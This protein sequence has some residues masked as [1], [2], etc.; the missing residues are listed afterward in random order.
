MIALVDDT[1][2]AT[3]ERLIVDADLVSVRP[4]L[5]AGM[6]P[7]FTGLLP[8]FPAAA[9]QARSDLT[10]LNS[11]A[12][13]ALRAD[14][15]TRAP[16]CRFLTNLAQQLHP[17]AEEQDVLD[18]LAVASS[19]SNVAHG[20]VGRLLQALAAAHPE[21]D[22]IEA[23]AA[24]AA[25]PV[26]HHPAGLDAWRVW[27]IA[28]HHAAGAHDDSLVQLLVAARDAAP[29]G[30]DR[31]TIADLIVHNDWFG[32]MGDAADIH[33]RIQGAD[34]SFA[35]NW[36]EVVAHSTRVTS[37]TLTDL[38]AVGGA[39]PI[40]HDMLRVERSGLAEVLTRFERDASRP[41]MV[42]V[43]DA[44]TGKSSLV[45][46]WAAKLAAGGDAVVLT[47][48]ARL[49][50]RDVWEQLRIDLHLPAEGDWLAA[51]GRAATDAGA[52]VTIIVDDGDEYLDGGVTPASLFASI[53]RRL[54]E[55][56]DGIRV[57]VV[58]GQ[59]T[60]RRI[61][62]REAGAL[63]RHRYFGDGIEPTVVVPEYTDDEFASAWARCQQVFEVSTG[64]DQLPVLLRAQMHNPALAVLVASTFKGKSVPAHEVVAAVD[65]FRRY[66]ELQTRAAPDFPDR[67]FLSEL[68]LSMYQQHSSPI[69]ILLL[70]RL[71][72][73][74]R[75]LTDQPDSV[76]NRLLD[77]GVL[78]RV[79]TQQVPPD[80]IEFTMSQFGAWVLA[81]ALRIEQHDALE[82]I[83]A[84][85]EHVDEYPPIVETIRILASAV[86][87]PHRLIPFADDARPAVRDVLVQALRD[88]SYTKP[89]VAAEIVRELVF[90]QGADQARTIERRRTGMMAAFE[91]SVA[92]SADDLTSVFVE[93][94]KGKDANLRADALDVL[95]MIWRTHPGFTNGVLSAMADDVAALKP[96][97][98]RRLVLFMGDL[99]I[100]LYT[101][102]PGWDVGEPTSELWH[103]VAVDRLHADRFDIPG[104]RELILWLADRVFSGKIFDGFLLDDPDAVR[105]VL[106][107]DAEA[108]QPLRAG[109][110][111]L[112]PATDIASPAPLTLL[113]TLFRSPHQVFRL[114]A[115]QATAVHAANDFGSAEPVVRELFG[116]LD[117]DGRMWL[118]MS[119]GVLIDRTPPEWAPV[120]DELAAA[121]LAA[122]PEL[123]TDPGV[124]SLGRA[125]AG[126]SGGI[127]LDQWLFATTLAHLK[128]GISEPLVERLIPIGLH[129]GNL[130]LVARCLDVIGRVGFHHPK[131]ALGVLERL[132]DRVGDEPAVDP[133][134]SDATIGA[135]G[136]IRTL[137]RD[138]VDD[139]HIDN[140]TSAAWR[141]RV[142][143]AGQ[144]DE[145]RSRL[146]AHVR[147]VG[148]YN[149]GVHQAVCFPIMRRQLLMPI[150]LMLC[151]HDALGDATKALTKQAWK[152]FQDADFTLQ[153]WAAPR[154]A[155][156][157]CSG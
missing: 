65:V 121:A 130:T 125:A 35:V 56:P 101:S 18:L 14:A 27:C 129:D 63:R 78:R 50:P 39:T 103:K 151:D 137:H 97:P 12:Y 11:L 47:T 6:E 110:E 10:V 57:I 106:A 117:R 33:L 29:A 54:D 131:P 21:V 77:N 80:A 87:D 68:S 116:R 120:L 81:E 85:L 53:N 52:H 146:R 59:S 83:R 3:L 147:L 138:L 62:S 107:L 34:R 70:G 155:V 113:E 112:D 115:A 31:D 15:M 49:R 51:L 46:D 88:L 95:Y 72:R 36:V 4:L 19:N 157:P 84:A 61:S 16:L 126:R 25:T 91:I 17:R 96:V 141:G 92:G 152:L 100:T 144:S 42:L 89:K 48:G 30:P 105:S 127:S 22:A 76:S 143:A 145:V 44:G 64:H 71:E 149:N 122:H 2:V 23:I 40:T 124:G 150:Y 93:I 99:S 86:D 9:D 134:V 104:V 153:R 109:V 102:H 60:W 41:A 55:L 119:M 118:L 132:W 123:G 82:A 75:Y 45:I 114:L 8:I 142:V 74:S 24:T 38:V 7:A 37:S 108:K 139:F 79:E 26:P 148:L 156:G 32:A 135:L 20:A 133:A 28:L 128:H 1:Q 136:A 5:L 94:A 111:L 13:L 67:G 140:D 58:F 90:G 73:L 66:Y 154:C 98:T 69:P 43:G